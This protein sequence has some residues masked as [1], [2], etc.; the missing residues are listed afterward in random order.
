MTYQIETMQATDWP[1]VR[2]IYE[3]GIE[4]GLATFETECPPWEEWDESHLA[5]CR[6]VARSGGKI[7]GWA[8][9]SPVSER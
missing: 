5:S 3:E 1:Q 7:L 4:T 6:Y 8:A 9:L 2:A